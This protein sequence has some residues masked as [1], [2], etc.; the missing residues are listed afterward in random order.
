LATGLQALGAVILSHGRMLLAQARAARKT[1]RRTS[2]RPPRPQADVLAIPPGLRNPLVRWWL[3]W[4]GRFGKSRTPEP[5]PGR[6][7][8]SDERR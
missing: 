4:G 8:V 2:A 1:A 6:K 7:P 5:P 3:Q